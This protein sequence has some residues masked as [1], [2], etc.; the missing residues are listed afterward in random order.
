MKS[1]SRLLPELYRVL[2][3]HYGP[4]NWWPVDEEYHRREGSDPRE[5][6]VI[7]AVL[8]QNT[9]WKNVE[10]AIE[11]LKE[12][13]LLSFEG[14]IETP[15]ELI[16]KLI[17]PSG[18]YR[19]KARRL[20]TVCKELDPVK[21][22]EE[23]GRDELLKI[24][25][26]GRETA[27]AILLYAGNRLFFVVDAYTKR[28]LHRLRNIEGDYERLRTLFEENLPEDLDIYKEFHALIDRHAK[29]HCRK[30]P[31]C[32]GCPL[33]ALCLFSSSVLSP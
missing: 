15:I 13:S 14:I 1:L 30:K 11:N 12:N 22:V 9:A 19:Q 26:I 5:E 4:Q 28:L 23:I 27:D 8:T 3:E 32:D 2:F 21:K 18:Y 20:K 17:R 6:I 25:G 29:E 10:R 33:R 16:E 7:G 24:P 31:V